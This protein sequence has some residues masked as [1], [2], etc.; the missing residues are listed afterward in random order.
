MSAAPDAT[1]M[2]FAIGILVSLGASIMNA[3]GLNLLKLDH[4]RNSQRSMHEQRNEC[5]RPMWHLGLYLY[6]A[7]Q[8]VGSTIALS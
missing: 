5:G 4:V 2:D 8:L 6:I 1:I 7:S 3:L